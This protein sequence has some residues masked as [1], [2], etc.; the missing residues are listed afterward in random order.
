MIYTFCSLAVGDE[1]Y[2]NNISSTF[3]DLSK[4]TT[5]SSF[6]ISSNN[7]ALNADTIITKNIGDYPLC[8][9]SGYMFNY[10]LKFLPIKEAINLNTKFIVFIDADW[11]IGEGFS[12]E[13]MYSL[14]VEMDRN[15]I[16]FIFERPHLIGASKNDL[17]NC[18]WKHKIIPYGLDKT[19]KYDFA[20]VCNEQ[21]LIFQNTPKLRTFVDCWEKLYWKSYEE[22]IWPFAEGVEIG[23]SITDAGMVGDYSLI[24]MLNNCFYFY[25]KSGNLHTRF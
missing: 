23:M 16:D 9:K 10:N 4:K 21:I 3:I 22:N 6:L 11:K 5:H 12:E 25:D 15:S 14:F 7:S 20:H 13:K 8:T 1:L 18:F 2:Y 19:N 17:N 24:R